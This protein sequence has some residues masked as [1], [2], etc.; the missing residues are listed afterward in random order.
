MSGSSVASKPD[1]ETLIELINNR[2]GTGLRRTGRSAAGTLGGAVFVEWPDGRPAVITRYLGPMADA[3]RAAEVLNDAR[4][5]GLPIPRHDHVLQIDDQVLF[6]QER[7]PGSPAEPTPA[8]IDMIIDLNDRFAG[9]L[10]DRLDVPALPLCLQHSG[11]PH[12]RHEVLAEHSDR[13][14][15]ILAVIRAIGADAPTTMIGNDLV[16]ID[17]TPSNVLLDAAGRLSGVVDWN[18]GA[19]RGDRHLALV[20]TRF[21]LEWSL[22]GP[23]PGPAA[24]AAA[25]LGDHLRQRVAPDLLRVYWAHR[26]LYQL[27]FALQSAPPDVVDWHLQVAEDRLL[28]KE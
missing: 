14:R 23:K 17:L 12:P 4:A 2:L 10:A 26:M 27:H 15:R 3:R 9:L 6:V 8:V 11:D 18:L 19:Y 20:K 28:A 1:D 22:H 25:R 5:L 21:E 7:L 16:H 24:E 13:S